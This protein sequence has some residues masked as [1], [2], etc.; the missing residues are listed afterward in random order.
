MEILRASL[1]AGAGVRLD[2]HLERQAELEGIGGAYL[3][4]V[5]HWPGVKMTP[6]GPLFPCQLTHGDVVSAS[7]LRTASGMEHLFAQGFHVFETGTGYVSPL[8]P[9]FRTLSESQLKRASGN[10]WSL[11]AVAAWIVYVWANTIKRLTAVI[12]RPIDMPTDMLRCG[13]SSL[14]F[15]ASHGE[16]HGEDDIE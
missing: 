15:Q 2:A 4:D 10:G 1:P 9:F 12:S 13:S 8:L 5:Q 7:K 6:G 3:F 16:Q 14:D 11:P